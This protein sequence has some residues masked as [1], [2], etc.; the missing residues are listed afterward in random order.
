MD[1]STIFALM[2][3]ILCIYWVAG[4]LVC[5]LYQDYQ[6]TVGHYDDEHELIVILFWPI[7]IIVALIK[8]IIAIIRR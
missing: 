3:V 4:L 1:Y 2:F 5:M 8:L 6:I 7:V